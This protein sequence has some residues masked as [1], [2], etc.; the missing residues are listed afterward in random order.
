M[1]RIL[2]RI[3]PLGATLSLALI[4]AGCASSRTYVTEEKKFIPL[5]HVK[6][7]TDELDLTKGDTVAMACTKCKTVLYQDVTRPRNR[8]FRTLEHRHYCPGCKSTI[9]VNW[10]GLKTNQEIKHTCEACGNDSVFCC[11]TKRASSVTEG[12][13]KKQDNP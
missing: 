1:K 3:I 9:T 2:S 11:A 13:E 4:I 10:T 7:T 6:N 8:F 12:M 5:H